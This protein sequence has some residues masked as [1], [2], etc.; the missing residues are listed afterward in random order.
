MAWRLLKKQARE[1]SMVTRANSRAGFTLIEF[2]IVIT[3][4]AILAA[5]A[6]PQTQQWMANQRLKAAARSVAD[7]F[8]LARENAI[9]TGDY[10]IVFFQKDMLGAALLGGNGL[11]VPI[12][13]LDDGRP[14]TAGQNCR[15]TAAKGQ[16]PVN[17][18]N[19]VNWG[20]T[21]A[22]A[23]APNDIGTGPMAS[24][25]SFVDPTGAATTW[26]M[27]GPNGIPVGVTAACVA[28]PTGSGG[29]AIYLTNTFRDYAVVLSPLGGVRV[30]T[31]NS[32]AAP[33]AWRQ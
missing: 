10:Q 12:L 19:G 13:T 6:V 32:V 5:L 8:T 16:T 29:G 17:A 7:A 26:V 4:I 25:S 24:G 14:G 15:I 22:T 33:P 11:P 2:A 9:R 23:R 20:I 30:T 3:I 28:G 31:W 1:A 18:Q 21:F 27:F